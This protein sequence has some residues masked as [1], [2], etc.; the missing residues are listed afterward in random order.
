MVLIALIILYVGT[1]LT[2]E[3]KYS[4]P[5]REGRGE[6]MLVFN[7][8]ALC[9]PHDYTRNATTFDAAGAGSTMLRRRAP[10]R[11]RASRFSSK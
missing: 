1:L 11:I 6:R 10:H 7:T 8:T 2:E 4:A 5:L 9:A 3:R